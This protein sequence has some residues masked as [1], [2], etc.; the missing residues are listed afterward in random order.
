MSPTMT[1]GLLPLYTHD[2]V[3]QED[4]VLLLLPS[5]HCSPASITPLPQAAAAGR[6]DRTLTRTRQRASRRARTLPSRTT[7]IERPPYARTPNRRYDRK[8]NF[9]SFSRAAPNGNR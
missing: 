6:A 1:S 2:V 9:G 5:S 7:T 4:D 3:Q 8:E